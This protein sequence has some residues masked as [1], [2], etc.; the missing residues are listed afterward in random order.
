DPA[1]GTKSWQQ[2]NKKRNIRLDTPNPHVSNPESVRGEILDCFAALA[3]TMLRQRCIKALGVVLA[4]AT[5]LSAPRNPPLPRM[6][7]LSDLAID[8]SR[9]RRHPAAIN[10]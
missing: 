8:F 10:R 7:A 9:P 3:M 2:S 5:Q 6:I 4:K 1:V